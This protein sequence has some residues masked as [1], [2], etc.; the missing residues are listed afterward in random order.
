MVIGPEPLLAVCAPPLLLVAA[1]A[2]RL[3]GRRLSVWGDLRLLELCYWLPSMDRFDAPP[4][5]A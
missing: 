3:G 4:S 1:V 5:G 2:A